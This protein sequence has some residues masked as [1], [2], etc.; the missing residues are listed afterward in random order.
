MTAATECR[1]A[2]ALRSSGLR[3]EAFTA[4]ASRLATMRKLAP[5]DTARW[6][7][8]VRPVFG[9]GVQG[10]NENSVAAIPSDLAA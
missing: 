3:A 10:A 9:A 1:N 5:D 4:C 8:E 7:S 6:R 2:A